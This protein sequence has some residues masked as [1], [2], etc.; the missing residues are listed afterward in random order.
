MGGA[1]AIA[2]LTYGSGPIPPSDV[3]VGPGNKFV[4]AAKSLVSGQVK[5]DMLAGPS[6]CL[7][8]GNLIFSWM[9]IYFNFN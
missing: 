9:I 6:E 4:T 8:L 2:A 3:V 5:I 7:V 1:Q